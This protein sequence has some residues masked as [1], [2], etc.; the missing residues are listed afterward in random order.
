V[1][2]NLRSL[3]FWLPTGQRA[4]FATWRRKRMTLPRTL[5]FATIA[6]GFV[7][8]AAQNEALFHAGPDLLPML[9]LL[10]L[11]VV[12]PVLGLAAVA[13][14]RGW[15]RQLTMALQTSA[16][17]AA[18]G[19]TLLMRHLALGGHMAYPSQISGI[20]LIAI[21][22]FGGFNWGRITLASLA[23]LGVS[24][25]LEYSA[26]S[27]LTPLLEIY[28]GILMAI[29]ACVGAVVQELVMRVAWMELKRVRRIRG[30][31]RDS[32]ERFQAFMNNN[33]AV[34]WMKDADGRYVYANRALRDFL[35]VRDESW[36]GRSDADFFTEEFARRSRALDLM[37]LERGVVT[38]VDGAA[39]DASGTLRHWTLV[40]FPFTDSAGRRFIGGVA[41]DVTERK[42]AE[43]L[44][45]M[46]ALTDELTGVYNRR[47]FMLLAQQGIEV[48]RRAGQRCAL[49]YVDL[50]GLKQINEEHGHA[51]G[52]AAILAVGEALRVAS[53]RSDVVGRIGGDEFV[54]FASGCD[55]LQALQARLAEAIR[56]YSSSR[57]VPF[58]LSATIGVSEFAPTEGVSLDEQMHRADEA[59]FARKAARS[60]RG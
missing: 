42:R 19:S 32:E 30:D 48:A 56:G 22:M 50:D 40:R 33:P 23:Y 53:R 24:V 45:R 49:I 44:V 26:E 20:I 1:R 34:A 52:D 15:P 14:Y 17:I 18:I 13:T 5:L 29:I 60:A 28:A 36:R 31:L 59:M 38:E 41:N 57:A 7:L 54:I 27:S 6:L 4:E 9:R 16:V 43:D 37:A 35:G 11:G 21:A 2:E 39:R 46:Q 47:G 55:D 10:E 25:R 51:G 58:R 3:P 8:A 12:A